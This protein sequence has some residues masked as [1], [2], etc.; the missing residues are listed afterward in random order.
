MRSDVIMFKFTHVPR[1]GTV[2]SVSRGIY[3]HVGILTGEFTGFDAGVISFSSRGVVEETLTSF[4]NGTTVRIE[5]YPGQLPPPL[6]VGRARGLSMPTYSWLSMN[7]EHFVRLAHGLPVESPQAR[8]WFAA[9]IGLI[10]TVSLASR[11]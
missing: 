4:A 1:A 3:R 6:V 8:A 7:C 5:G 9:A 2:V 11:T 10:M